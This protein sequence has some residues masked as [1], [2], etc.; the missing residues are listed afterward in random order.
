MLPAV[1]YLIV[2][3]KGDPY[4]EG[5]KCGVCGAIFLG[6]RSVCS[7]CFARDKISK[8]KLSN[9]GTLY[10]CS[11]VYRSFPGID[12]PSISALVDLD[13]GGTVNGNLITV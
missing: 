7:K 5:H 1:D 9:T 4:L 13:A 8:I 10:S 2:P 12:V 11:V 6:E 3:D